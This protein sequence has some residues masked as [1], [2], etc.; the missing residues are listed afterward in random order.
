MEGS[1]VNNRL[2]VIATWGGAVNDWR[3]VLQPFKFL[4]SSFQTAINI[5]LVQLRNYLLTCRYIGVRTNSFFRKSLSA[6]S[7][8][9]ASQTQFIMD[10][11]TTTATV[12]PDAY[13]K[14]KRGESPLT[15]NSSSSEDEC[16]EPEFKA[17]QTL[18]ARMKDYEAKVDYTLPNAP[19]VMRVDGH[20]F[21]KFTSFFQK[22]FDARIHEAMVGTCKDLLQANPAATVG[23]TFSDEITL[24]FPNGINA[25]NNRVQKVSSLA[26]GL[27]SVRFAYHL[28]AAIEKHTELP[29][30]KEKGIEKLNSTHFDAR[31]FT[32]PSVD[33]ALNCLVW[34]CRG[35]AIRNAVSAFARRY[36]TSKQLARKRTGQVLEMLEREKGVVF[37]EKAPK[38]AHE[39]TMVKRKLVEIEGLNLKTQQMEKAI[40]TRMLEV[41]RGVVEYSQENLKLVTD[42]YWSAN[43]Y[44]PPPDQE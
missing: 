5:S 3:P 30:I 4:I 24:V 35:D 2:G 42:K 29:K 18:A 38:W 33:E 34:R 26:A 10:S 32:V 17:G 8:R 15:R 23:Y 43:N 25:F 14:R 13:L 19:T 27:A 20:C 1:K 31:V 40:R 11:V 41:D 16:G 9:V 12:Q 37:A 44:R 36:Y 28:Q 6:A 22:P 39:G 7:K 21:S